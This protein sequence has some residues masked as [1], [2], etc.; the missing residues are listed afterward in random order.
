[1]LYR[2]AEGVVTLADQWQDQS[3]N[4]LLPTQ[5]KVQGVNLVVARDQLPLGMAFRDYVIQQRHNFGS[6]LAGL[7]MI[8]DAPGVVDER[9]AHFLEFTWR[10]D[11]K[12]VHQV[13]AM[14][15]H[16]KGALLNFTGSIPGG[17]EPSAREALVA[18]ITSFKFAV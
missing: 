3:I 16:D 13:M 17:N 5:S 10:S 6:Q 15:L 8:A 7:E 1:M 11:G 14:V 4:V 12:P 18:S 2:I 9:E